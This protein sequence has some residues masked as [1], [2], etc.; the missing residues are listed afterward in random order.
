MKDI[1]V[2]VIL[3]I[4]IN[5]EI[6]TMTMYVLIENKP[7]GKVTASLIGWPNI[8]AQASTEIEAVNRLRRSL[9]IQLKTAKVI[10]LE[11]DE[12]EPWLQT[13]GMFKDDP[14]ADELNT[15]IADYRATLDATAFYSGEQKRC[16]SLCT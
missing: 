16:S 8:H 15:I 2:G 7:E 13:A 1:D 9:T 6:N 3:C 12:Q 14:F 4:N 10:P 5:E 11:L